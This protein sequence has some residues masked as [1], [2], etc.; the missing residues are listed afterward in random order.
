[1]EFIGQ[2]NILLII[3]IQ[4]QH[5]SPMWYSTQTQMMNNFFY[6][7]QNSNLVQLFLNL[8]QI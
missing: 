4:Y 8:L 1:M 7:F 3:H 5:N 2:Q 6:Y